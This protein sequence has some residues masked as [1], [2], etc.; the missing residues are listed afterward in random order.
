MNECRANLL[1]VT[2]FIH[3]ADWQIGKPFARIDDAHKSAL[4]QQDRLNMLQ[5]IGEAAK[6]HRAE[7]ILVA[8]DLFDTPT[9]TK[10]TV[11][12]ACSAI[13][14][15]G[16]PVLAIPGNHE[17][18]GPAS[19]WEQ[20]FFQREQASLAPNFRIILKPHHSHP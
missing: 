20:P 5:R 13:G 2:R 7:F 14:S 8:G 6:E 9:V 15:L 11:S 3:T 4:V 1:K 12:A 10:A 18:G 19:I 17:H 16:I